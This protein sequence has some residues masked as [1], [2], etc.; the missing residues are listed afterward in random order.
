[1]TPAMIV[2]RPGDRVLV[3]LTDEPEPEDTTNI[4]RDLKTAFPGVEFVLMTGV[5]GIAVQSP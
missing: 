2:L 4:T 5:S 3:T 1:M